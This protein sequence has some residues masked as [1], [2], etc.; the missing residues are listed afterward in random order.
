MKKP[1]LFSRLFDD[2]SNYE[3][4]FFLFLTLVMIGIGVAALITSPALHSVG[5]GVLFAALMAIHI[6]LYWQSIWAFKHRNWLIPYLTLQLAIAFAMGMMA[7]QI[8]VSFGLY[9]GLIGLIIGVPMKRLSKALIIFVVL[10]VS[11]V[12]YALLAGFS[13]LTYWILG[14]VPVVVFVGIYVLMY[15]RQA[16]AREQAQSLLKDLEVANR[17]LSEY[18]AR[19]EDLTIANERQRMARELH[20]TLSQGL[21]GL[22][23]QLEASDAHLAGDRPE[24]ARSIL[25]QAMEKARAT[26]AEARQAIDNLR[27]PPGRN[28]AESIRQEAEHFSSSTG[29]ACVPQIQLDGDIP[30]KIAEA[31]GKVVAEGLTNIARHARAKHV[32]LRLTGKIDLL[33]IE[34]CDDGVGFDPET[35]QAGHYGLL[36]M[37]ERIRLAGGQFDVHSTPGQGTCLLIR[38]PV[39]QTIHA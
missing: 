23:L 37:R 14:M 38:F 20:D 1:T 6:W 16:E 19:V 31:A 22:I 17:Q 39:E 28:L 26:L 8:G 9:P 33:E 5:T 25:Q 24:R 4:P 10:G 29:I 12:N 30:E 21:A 27:Q 15:L 2:Q 18:A 11:A 3:L 7:R 35:I 36:G 34:I 32:T 13:R